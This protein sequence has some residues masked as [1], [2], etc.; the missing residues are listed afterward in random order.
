MIAA[1]KRTKLSLR[2]YMKSS[3][4]LAALNPFETHVILLDTILS[5]WRLYIAYLTKEV[6]EQARIIIYVVAAIPDIRCSLIR[7]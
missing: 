5:N 3:S 2:R 7:C 1:S 4:D 6:T